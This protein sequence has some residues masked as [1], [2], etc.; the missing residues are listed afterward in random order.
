MSVMKLTVEDIFLRYDVKGA[1]FDYSDI[2]ASLRKLDSE[3]QNRPEYQYE[4]TAFCL[5]P[6]SENNPWGTYYGPQFT[7]ADEKG[8]PIYAPTQ[9]DVSKDA[10]LYWERRY[11]QVSN[12]LLKMRYSALVWDFKPSVVQ[13]AYPANLYKSY[14]DSMLDVCDNDFS[15]HPVVT[16]NIYDRL[17]A[18]VNKQESD[19]VRVKS[20]LKR[21]ES[22]YAVDSAVR[23]W[24][25]QF[26]LM[27]EYSKC[28]SL[29]EK[30]TLVKAHE[31]RL[32]RLAL[33][34][35]NAKANV[36]LIAKQCHLLCDY[37]NRQKKM[38]DVKRVLGVE[39]YSHR[40]NF[41]TYSP[42]QKQGIL[43]DLHKKYLHYGLVED[44][45]RIISELQDTG[46]ANAASMNQDYFEYKI[47]HEILDRAELMFGTGAASDKER[48]SNFAAY[49][50]PRKDKEESS[51]KELVK[52]YPL[53]YMVTTNMMD[54]KGRPMSVVKGYEQDPEGSLILYITEK[55]NLTDHFLRIA[56]KKMIDVGLLKSDRLMSELIEPCPLFEEES[57]DIIKQ[58][59]DFFF[60]D[61]YSIMC[62]LIVPQIENAVRNLVQMSNCPVIKPQG[63]GMIGF[64]LITLDELLRSKPIE[65]AFTPDGAYYLRLVLTDQRSLN[66]RNL[67]CHGIMPPQYFEYSAAIRL[68]HVLVMLGMV[69]EKN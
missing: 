31:E 2:L 55:M 9:E 54:I 24:A 1:K 62:H 32:S 16:A 40:L 50:I 29:Q 46:E 28:F 37:Y 18:L 27:L 58:S 44:S 22:R 43:Q 10:V 17:F 38:E 59:L 41:M 34:D 12:S 33:T 19:V 5:Q 66:I 45:K 21:Y 4:Y 7:F 56:V 64:Q 8:N 49:F 63:K 25:C 30:V 13:Q 47:P 26:L 6:G 3:E 20:S 14:V 65:D 23:S 39:E 15:P 42:L 57:Y 61:K 48:W 52:K 60:D 51:L 69:R 36:W 68:L 53:K 67:L 35:E 11:R